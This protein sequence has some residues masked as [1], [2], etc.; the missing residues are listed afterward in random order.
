MSRRS[1]TVTELGTEAGVDLDEVLVTLWDLG[2]DHV[3]NANDT[4]SHRDVKRAR[5][6]LGVATRSELRSLD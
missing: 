5:Q 4:V 1:L 3:L 2:V 6:A